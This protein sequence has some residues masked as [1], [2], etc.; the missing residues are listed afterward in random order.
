MSLPYRDCHRPHLDTLMPWADEPVSRWRAVETG[1]F[2][3]RGVSVARLE[4]W[5]V[6]TTD[7]YDSTRFD[8]YPDVGEAMRDA[9]EVMTEPD[10][11]GQF[12]K[13]EVDDGRPRGTAMAP[14]GP[15]DLRRNER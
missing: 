1:K 10:S 9:R 7:A 13:W 15:F 6:T 11:R 14:G 4:L 8:S 2:T 3:N 12:R 5:I